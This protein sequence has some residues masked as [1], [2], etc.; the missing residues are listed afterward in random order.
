VLE[1]RGL[2]TA[3]QY[4]TVVPV[5]ESGEAE[6]LGR[7]AAWFPVVGV[8]M[9]ALLAG[10]AVV[11]ALVAP[12]LVGAVLL[13]ALWAAVTGGLHLDGVA[14]TLDGLGGG[15]SREEALAIMRDPGTGAYGAAAIVLV[16]ALKI[17][18]LASLPAGL[19]WR[20]ALLAPV[21]GRI[22][23]LVL[24]PLC[25]PARAD[26]AGHAFARSLRPSA[27]APASVI[28]VAAALGCVGVWGWL[29]IVVTAAQAGGFALVL[30][31]RLGGF[32]GDGLGA[33][34][35]TTEA[36]ILALAAILAFHGRM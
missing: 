11:T 23:P 27:L 1:V 31:R 12:P 15:W 21:L 8:A 18:A 2:L 16:V 22:A 5:P 14:D 33:L 17:A 29:A 6:D 32:T 9:G 20:A 35:E 19:A 30:R 13:V 28:G 4:L 3:C 34:V 7:A 10:A 25:P 26:G 24:V 36:S